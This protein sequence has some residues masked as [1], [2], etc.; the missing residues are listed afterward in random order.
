MLGDRHTDLPRLLNSPF[1]LTTTFQYGTMLKEKA[2]QMHVIVAEWL[3]SGE[4]AKEKGS[5]KGS[6]STN[7]TAGTGTSISSA[8]LNTIIHHY[9]PKGADIKPKYMQYMV[10]EGVAAIIM[11]SDL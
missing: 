4:G 5:K 6:S 10:R 11:A 9:S 3:E 1:R 2:G 8:N 7:D